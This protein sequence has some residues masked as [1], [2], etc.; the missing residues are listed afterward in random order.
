MEGMKV[1]QNSLP[2]YNPPTTD[3]E[4]AM[5]M[6]SLALERIEERIRENKASPSEL[7]YCAKLG[8]EESRLDRQIQRE[9]VKLL[10]AR[11]EDI[12][13]SKNTEELYRKAIEAFQTYNGIGVLDE[14]GGDED[15]F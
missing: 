15:G 13:R 14:D 5:Q 10:Q 12:Q 2:R 11:T 7:L 3:E 4:R 8:S 9:N 1:D 6:A